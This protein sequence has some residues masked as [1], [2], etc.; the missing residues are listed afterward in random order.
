M[1]NSEFYFTH[2]HTKMSM[3][4]ESGAVLMVEILNELLC[5]MLLQLLEE[6]LTN[7]KLLAWRFVICLFF[8]PPRTTHFPGTLYFYLDRVLQ[9]VPFMFFSRVQILSK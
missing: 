2:L 9:Y 1:T 6:L 7:S 5:M 3:F 8:L 4:C